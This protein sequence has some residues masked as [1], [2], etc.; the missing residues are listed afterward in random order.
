MN[1]DGAYFGK[2]AAL[3]QELVKPFLLSETIYV[4]CLYEA[5][6]NNL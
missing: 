2:Y 5:T 3:K 4:D 6:S 1:L